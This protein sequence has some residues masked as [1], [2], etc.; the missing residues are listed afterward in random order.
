MPDT[1]LASLPSRGDMSNFVFYAAIKDF[2]L[3]E[4]GLITQWTVGLAQRLGYL[5]AMVALPMLTLWILL[6]GYRIVTGRSREPMMAQ[7]ADAARASLIVFI[8]TGA[9]M[10]N[11][12]IAKQIGELGQVISQVVTGSSGM[13][14]QIQESL[15]WMQFALTSI[16]ALPTGGDAA[17]AEAKSQARLFTGIG[18][19]AASMMG[20]FMLI[21]YE[22]VIRFMVAMGPLAI[23]CLLFKPTAAIFQRWLQNCV[24]LLFYLATTAVMVTISLKMVTAVAAA[25]W[26]DR[27]LNAAVET[28][29]GGVDLHMAEGITSMAMQQGGMGIILTL[30]IMSVPLKAGEFFLGTLANFTHYSIFGGAGGQAAQPGPQGQPAGSYQPPILQ[31]PQG[32]RHL[33]ATPLLTKT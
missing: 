33:V 15:G 26:A 31:S 14:N 11:P 29:S 28:I 9:S 17:V 27:L 8:A 13:D 25:F 16:D 12:W 18:T 30:L 24:S 6:A 22:I 4:D 2:L 7:V 10:G 23:M 19:A 20:G 1:L 21:L 5:L 3:G 32:S